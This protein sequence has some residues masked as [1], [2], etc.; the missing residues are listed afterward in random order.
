[1]SRY[2]PVLEH[3]VVYL[4]CLECE[5]RLCEKEYER[6]TGEDDDTSGESDH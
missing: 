5:D 3:R 2:C 6:K 1:M 4:D